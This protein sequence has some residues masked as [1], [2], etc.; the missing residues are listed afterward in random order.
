[1]WCARLDDRF[2]RS[3]IRFARI[4]GCDYR[5]SYP[6]FEESSIAVQCRPRASEARPGLGGLK[7]R[8]SRDGGT[9]VITL[10]GELD[11]ASAADVER[12]LRSLERTDLVVALD[13]RELTFI[14]SAGI[15]VIMQ[16]QRQASRRGRRLVVVK[17]NPAVQRLFEICGLADELPFVAAPPSAAPARSTGTAVRRALGTRAGPSARAAVRRRADEAALAAAVRELRTHPRLT[18]GKPS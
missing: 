10:V 11:V 7:I 8:S 6:S 15:A 16:A 18:A 14:A 9:R 3:P 5:F 17:G 13:L 12:T 1:L 4:A 2:D